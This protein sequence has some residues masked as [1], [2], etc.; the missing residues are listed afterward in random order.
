LIGLI[1]VALSSLLMG[2]HIL[3]AQK[4]RWQRQRDEEAERRVVEERSERDSAELRVLKA[5]YFDPLD[6]TLKDRAKCNP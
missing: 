6:E 2:D 5:D 4:Q 1:A 3:H